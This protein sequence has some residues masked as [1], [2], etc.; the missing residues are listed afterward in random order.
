MINI[1]QTIQVFQ[2]LRPD[3]LR[4]LNPLHENLRRKA[5]CLKHELTLP[6]LLPIPLS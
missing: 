5:V 4:S 6:L 1:Y 3:R 2:W